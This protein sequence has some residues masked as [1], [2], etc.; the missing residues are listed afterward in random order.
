MESTDKRSS[1]GPAERI[2][3]YGANSNMGP[4]IWNFTEATDW[5]TQVSNST[6][7]R[8]SQFPRPHHRIFSSVLNQDRLR[9]GP[10]F[11]ITETTA[12]LYILSQGI[13]PFLIFLFRID[14]VDPLNMEP[15]KA[16]SIPAFF[17]QNFSRDLPYSQIWWIHFSSFI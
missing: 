11:F 8:V 14:E 7:Q 9:N 2:Q 10:S 5:R 15:V 17:R 6:L 3:T 1:Y 13:S 4:D 16:Y 12:L